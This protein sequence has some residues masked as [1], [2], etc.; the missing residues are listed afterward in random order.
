MVTLSGCARWRCE[1]NDGLSLAKA[2]LGCM[3]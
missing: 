3:W 1:S 2:D